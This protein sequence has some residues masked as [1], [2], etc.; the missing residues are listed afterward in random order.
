MRSFLLV[1]LAAAAACRGTPAPSPYAAIADS[2]VRGLTAQEIDDLLEGRGAGYARTA[3]LNGYP[4]PRHVLELGVQL[5][6]R[7]DQRAAA[8]RVFGAMQADARRVGADIVARERALSAAFQSRRVSA[9]ELRARVDTLATLY[10]RLRAVHL[11]AHLE[12]TAV[13]TPAQVR[14]YDALRGYEHAGAAHRHEGG[15]D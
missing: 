1:L 13:L 11:A 7:A 10:G 3:E 14:R 2:P 12:M 9:A 8:E 4:G 15:D 6:L 5:E